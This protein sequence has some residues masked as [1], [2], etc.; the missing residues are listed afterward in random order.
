MEIDRQD[1]SFPS[2]GD[3]L[4]G[5]LYGPRTPSGPCPAIVMAH[6]FGAVKEM[7]LDRFAEVF[8][9]AGFVVLVFDYRRLGASD[10][11]PRQEIDPMA[12]VEDY[13]NA[14]TWIAARDE[15]DPARIGVWGTS[16]SGG[17]VL[18]LAATDPRVKCVVSQVPTISGNAVTRRRFTPQ[19]LDALVETQA[20]DRLA[21]MQGALPQT[22]LL[23]SD[24]ADGRAVYTAPDAVEWYESAAARGGAWRN[25]VTLRSL[26]YSRA[27]EPGA[28]VSFIAPTPLLMIVAD[29]D[30]VTPTD[31]ALGAYEQAREPKS[32]AMIPGGHFAAYTAAFDA[33][34]A[35]ARDWF[36]RFLR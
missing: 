15:V 20:K 3:T 35:A 24:I 5:W 10:G 2:E 33:A 11:V 6:G 26:E 21:R 22:R 7:Y 25:E 4:R 8:A 16:Y 32:L 1:I 29:R 31:L 30:S 14:I 36:V 19:A 9:A 18:V 13:R 12:Q 27:Y 17:H 23:V 28:W 34:S